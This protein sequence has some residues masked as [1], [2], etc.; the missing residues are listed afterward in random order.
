MLSE[1]RYIEE[2]IIIIII[3]LLEKD[4]GPKHKKGTFEAV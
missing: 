1:W 4:L 2:I 3:S